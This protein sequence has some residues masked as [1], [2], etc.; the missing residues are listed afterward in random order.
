M[1]HENLTVVFRIVPRL[2]HRDVRLRSYGMY[3]Q[4]GCFDDGERFAGRSR[5]REIS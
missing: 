5:P 4:A 3:T 2:P 1:K